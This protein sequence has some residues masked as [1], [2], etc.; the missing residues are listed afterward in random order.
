MNKQ[1]E[2]IKVEIERLKK[3]FSYGSSAEAKYRVEAYKELLDFINSLPEDLKEQSLT[4]EDIKKL[5]ALLIQMWNKQGDNKFE[6]VL[7]KFKAGG[8]EYESNA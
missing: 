8:I 3:E 4:V 2:L 7:E 6:Q 5:D 1:V